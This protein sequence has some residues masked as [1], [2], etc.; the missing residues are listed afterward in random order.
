MWPMTNILD[1][2][3]TDDI[4]KTHPDCM[5]LYRSRSLL[6]WRLSGPNP[7]PVNQDMPFNKSP[8]DLCESKNDSPR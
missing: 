8:S 4:A 6:K 2:T 7:D 1:S 5:E 3:A